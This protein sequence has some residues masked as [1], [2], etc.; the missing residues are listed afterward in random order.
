MRCLAADVERLDESLPSTP[1][2]A[3]EEEP[4]P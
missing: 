3:I 1:E 4:E 2:S